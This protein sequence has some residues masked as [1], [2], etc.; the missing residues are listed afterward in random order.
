MSRMLICD[1]KDCVEST[2][3]GTYGVPPNWAQFKLTHTVG[4]T[5]ESIDLVFCPEHKPYPDPVKDKD[6][7]IESLREFILEVLEEQPS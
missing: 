2:K 7:L 1:H 4:F 5:Q 6:I 3:C